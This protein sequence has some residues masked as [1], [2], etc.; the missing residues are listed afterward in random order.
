MSV[1]EMLLI[2]V[3]LAMDACAV[4]AC[5]GLAMKQVRMS[6]VLVMAI[7]FGL[8]QAL[9]PV[10]GWLLGSNFMQAIEP[11]DHWIAFVLLAGIG[12]KMIWDAFHEDSCDED[13]ACEHIDWGEL[14]VLSVATSIDALAVGVSFAALGTHIALPATLIGIV[15]F[16]LSVLGVYAGHHLGAR[17][18]RRAGITGGVILIGIGIKILLEHL[19]F[20]G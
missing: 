1:I 5:K 17:F 14:L 16:A 4:S 6:M 8:F 18:E 9:M 13:C 7:S 20:L 12:A 11:I 15:T 19:G 3:G 2:A 10:A